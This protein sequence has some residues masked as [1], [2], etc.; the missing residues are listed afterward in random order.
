M[1]DIQATKLKET[2]G[3]ILFMILRKNNIDNKWQGSNQV[4]PILTQAFHCFVLK[5][6]FEIIL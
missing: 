4:L 1:F 6:G 2:L 3:I 5:L